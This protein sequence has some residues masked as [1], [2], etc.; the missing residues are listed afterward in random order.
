MHFSSPTKTNDFPVLN[1]SNDFYYQVCD[2]GSYDVSI[3]TDRANNYNLQTADI[4]EYTFETYT[5][6][7]IFS[8]CVSINYF[9]YSMLSLRIYQLQD[10][11]REAIETIDDILHN[12]NFSCVD[13][14]EQTEEYSQTENTLST[15]HKLLHYLENEATDNIN[16]NA[17]CS[18]F[19]CP[20]LDE[21]E[22]AK[23]GDD[24]IDI[25]EQGRIR[26][27]AN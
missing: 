8:D 14:A 25:V 18:S 19:D 11:T 16:L 22:S 5:K 7:Q 20:N 1:S 6:E 17:C 3:L 21:L 12:N 13:E 24:I 2:F 4:I 15:L 9:F 10:Y 26:I 23:Q 27:L